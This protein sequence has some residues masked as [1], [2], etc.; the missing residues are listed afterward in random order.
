MH[1]WKRSQLDL[2]VHTKIILANFIMQS[3]SSRSSAIKMQIALRCIYANAFSA[4]E[5]ISTCSCV[6]ADRDNQK[7]LKA[8]VS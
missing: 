8:K 4:L 6:R 5:P 7:V 3:T 1:G 2:Y